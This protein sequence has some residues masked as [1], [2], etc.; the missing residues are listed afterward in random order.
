M[1]EDRPAPLRQHSGSQALAL[2]FD[3]GPDPHWTPRLL[4]TLRDLEVRATFFPI[5]ARARSHPELV[6]RTLR[7]GHGVGL[8]G[9]LHLRHP[10]CPADLLAVDT[11]LAVAWLAVEDLRLW[12]PPY[13]LCAAPTRRLAAEYGLELI[14]WSVDTNDWRASST[15]SAMLA[16]S[17][18]QIGPGAVVLMHDGIG[19]GPESGTDAVRS[20]CAPTLDLVGQLVAESRARGLSLAPISE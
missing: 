20:S 11:R 12:R 2:S 6:R 8:H 7:E 10:H 1:T 19:P 18:P 4:D 16:H 3:D 17:A 5:S 15:V 9:A 14:G 13:G